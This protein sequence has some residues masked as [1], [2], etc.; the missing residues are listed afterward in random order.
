MDTQLVPHRLPVAQSRLQPIRYLARRCRAVARRLR[1][2]PRRCHRVRSVG[3]VIARGRS[4]H[5]RQPPRRCSTSSI[6]ESRASTRHHCTS[7]CIGRALWLTRYLPVLLAIFLGGWLA[8]KV[9]WTEPAGAPLPVA[10]VQ[11]NVPLELKWQPAY[12]DA[13]LERYRSLSEQAGDARLIV[14]PEAAIPARLDEIDPDYLVDLKQRN[15]D[16]LIGVIERDEATRQHYNSVISLGRG[17]GLYRKQH[18][19]PFGEFLPFPGLVPLAAR[20]P[21]HPDVGF[22]FWSRGPATAHGGGTENRRV[23]VLRRRLRRRDHPCLAASEHC[24]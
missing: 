16:F 14:W 12:R 9:E 2:E 5:P 4:R 13:I 21:A 8:G 7:L 6:P 24:W 11:G 20:Q 18:L 1:C 17:A 19:V 3:T 22:Q 23:G 15:A 10:L